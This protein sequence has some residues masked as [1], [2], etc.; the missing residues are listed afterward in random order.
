[1]GSIELDAQSARLKIKK[2]IEMKFATSILLLAVLVIYSEA[3]P[4]GPDGKECDEKRGLKLVGP[5]CLGGICAYP[6][7]VDPKTDQVMQSLGGC[8][9][10]VDFDNVE[11]GE[12]SW[13][14]S[15]ENDNTFE[16][17]WHAKEDGWDAEFQK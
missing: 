6:G 4:N 14:N 12:N 13:E 10:V 1:M 2:K 5:D 9:Y 8:L 15:L 3:I 7:Q 11:E 17:G 16:D